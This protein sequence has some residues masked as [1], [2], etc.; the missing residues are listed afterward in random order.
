[1]LNNLQR[2]P[3]TN[4][5]QTIPQNRKEKI[6]YPISNSYNEVTITLIH[7]PHKEPIE[8]ELQTNFP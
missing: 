2:R 3:N 1:M 4:T 6:L 7:K 5:P 8:R